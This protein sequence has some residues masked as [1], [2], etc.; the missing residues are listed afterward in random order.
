LPSEFFTV[1]GW[2][3]G[4][5]Y[6]D[7]DEDVE[8][9]DLNV[10]VNLTYPLAGNLILQLVSPSGTSIFLSEGFPAGQ[11]TGFVDTVFDDEA[12]TL[13]SAGTSPFTGSYQPFDSLTGESPLSA[14]D[15]EST[16]GTW[17]LEVHVFDRFVVGTL[18]SWSLEVT[19]GDG[20]GGDQSTSAVHDFF[21]FNGLGSL[22][23]S[24]ADLLS[25]DFGSHLSLMAVNDAYGGSVSLDAD[26][27]VTFTP[28]EFGYLGLAD[29][30]YTISDGTHESTGNVT[31][32]ARNPFPWHHP[33]TFEDSLDVDKDL[34]VTS[35]DALMIINALN[36]GLTDVVFA[37][38][39]AGPPA[40]YYDADADNQITPTDAL[41]VINYLNSQPTTK[42]LVASASSGGVT[43]N[44]TSNSP[45]SN[46][47]AAAVTTTLLGDE[48][49]DCTSVAP[50]ASSTSPV[51]AGSASA[52]KLT[53]LPLVQ[54]NADSTPNHQR[55][56]QAAVDHLFA[57]DD[58]D[59][60]LGPLGL[61][62]GSAPAWLRR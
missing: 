5:S 7:V 42:S 23:L 14:F 26:G 39:G 17:H 52:A 53:V 56:R 41:V 31:I 49:T 1:F 20:S 24:A 10:R 32:D 11:T 37:P 55:H 60:L 18:N 61:A 45:I 48:A 35:T 46:A 4:D 33:G 6:F 3:I 13:I 47:Q 57:A 12:S 43:A 40:F 30:D 22:V 28:N 59:E 58:L 62:R 19:P 29:F 38:E 16:L 54:S 25:N 50:P 9:G 27:T 8:I 36:A 34:R 2:A 15:G 21:T 44:A 51:S